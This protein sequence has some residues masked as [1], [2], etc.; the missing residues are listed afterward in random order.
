MSDHPLHVDATALLTA[1]Q[2]PDDEQ[3]ELRRTLLAHLAAHDDAMW[4][5]CAH[6]HLTGS[7]L[8]VDHAW[9]RVL[10]TL[11]PRV[12]RW[13]Q[14]GGHCERDDQSLAG[15]AWRE[16]IEESGIGSLELIADPV[17][18]DIHAFDCPRGR[19]NR[20]LD[21]R[22]VAVAPAGAQEVVSDESDAL[23]W[24]A[25]DALPDDLDISTHR[26][27]TRARRRHSME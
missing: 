7:A 4:R 2:A 10:L 17:D 11:H 12:G 14:M 13:V 20:H 19:P 16:A 23:G 3:E 22:F 25:F 24:F 15:V 26:L 1:W 27:I 6:G 21:V 18:L 8:V 5:T 9:A